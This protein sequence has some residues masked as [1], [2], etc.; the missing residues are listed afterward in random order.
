[1]AADDNMLDLDV[2]FSSVIFTLFVGEK[3]LQCAK[4]LSLIK[5]IAKVLSL[6]FVQVFIHQV[7]TNL[8]T[9]D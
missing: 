5:D 9:K 1:M 7:R 6:P 2:Q 4:M 3:I 8:L